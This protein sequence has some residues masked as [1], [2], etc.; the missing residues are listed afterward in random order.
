MIDLFFKYT[1]KFN[2]KQQV[3]NTG[4]YLS[5]LLA[6]LFNSTICSICSGI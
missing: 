6:I 3:T 4:L 2:F 5:D 1:H